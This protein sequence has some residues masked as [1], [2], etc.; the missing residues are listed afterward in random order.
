MGVRGMFPVAGLPAVAGG[1]NFS[2]LAYEAL[3]INSQGY[4]DQSSGGVGLTSASYDADGV[5]TYVFDGQGTYPGEIIYAVAAYCR[6]ADGNKV[7]LTTSDS[8]MLFVRLSNMNDSSNV[9]GFKYTPT[10]VLA[11]DLTGVSSSIP[12]QYFYASKASG[13]TTTT[14]GFSGNWGFQN[15]SGASQQSAQYFTSFNAGNFTS[16][17]AIAFSTT[18]RLSQANRLDTGTRA[19]GNPLYFRFHVSNIG[20][21]GGSPSPGDSFKAKIETLAIKFEDLS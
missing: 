12:A 15:L 4:T 2:D 18:A 8:F 11:T 17:T 19:T 7:T 20:Q 6:D 9:S 14:F 16:T 10:F 21:G 13:G 5:G 1:S 3:N